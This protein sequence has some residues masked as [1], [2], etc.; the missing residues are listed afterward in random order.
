[1]PSTSGR[2]YGLP[3]SEKAVNTAI[4]SAVP[5]KTK[6]QTEWS[7]RVWEQ[8]ARSRNGR[9]LP[10]EQLFTL[11]FGTLELADIYIY[12]YI[13]IYLLLILYLLC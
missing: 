13:F 1:M 9:L 10:G 11:D 6:Q 2:S 4:A 7:I 3:K 12:I 8:W 5:I